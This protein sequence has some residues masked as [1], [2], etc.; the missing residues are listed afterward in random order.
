MR[1]S[2]VGQRARNKTQ[3]QLEESGAEVDSGTA[4]LKLHRIFGNEL[5]SKALSGPVDEHAE[6]LRQQQLLAAA[7]IEIPE[8]GASGGSSGGGKGSGALNA[9][10]G[11]MG[12]NAFGLGM[13][14]PSRTSTNELADPEGFSRLAQSSAGRALPKAIADRLGPAMGADVSGVQVHTDNAAVEM[15]RAGRSAGMAIGGHIY[16]GE[17]TAVDENETLIEEVFHTVQAAKGALPNVNGLAISNPN[18]SAEVEA[19]NAAK[20]IDS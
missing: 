3:T 11:G 17:G 6:Q 16:L 9:R 14:M 15:N 7:G 13:V 1:T 20:R 19:R 12:A 8:A 5:V 2:E 4:S 10:A 18:D